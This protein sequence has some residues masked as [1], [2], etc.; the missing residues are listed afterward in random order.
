M[1]ALSET[2]KDV[3][4]RAMMLRLANDYA[5]LADRAEARSDGRPP[6]EL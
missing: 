6:K 4:A 3:Q 1:R 2:M 5:K